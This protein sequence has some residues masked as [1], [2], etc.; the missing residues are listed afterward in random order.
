MD[1]DENR[2]L[3]RSLFRRCRAT[4]GSVQIKNPGE[5]QIRSM[6]LDLRTGREKP[7]IRHPGEYYAVNC[8]FCNDT[9]HRCYINHRYGTDDELGRAQT[10]L[11]TC[12]NAGCPLSMRKPEIYKQLE[13]MLTG[14]NLVQLRHAPI[15]EGKLVDVEK[16][17][18]TWPGIVTRVDKLPA[19]HEAVMYLAGRGFDVEVI[20]RFYNVHWCS[21]S[22]RFVCENRLIIPVYHNKQMVGWQARPAFDT[23]WKTS[24]LPKYYIS[25][26]MPRRQILYNLGNA[27]RFQTGVIVE[28]ETDVWRLG[29][30]AV[31]TFGATMT[32]PQ[33]SLFKSAF[34][35]HSGV[36]LYDP[37]VKEKT[38]DRVQQIVHELNLSLKSGFCTV[39]LP[40]GTDPG[41]LDRS[42]LRD[43]IKQKAEEKGVKVSWKKR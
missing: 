6:G 39:D 38:A 31:C 22:D 20:G 35:T 40:D 41:S 14:H 43:F 32:E 18:G 42:F 10:F 34:A 28:G 27:R 25:P 19:S 12:F 23:D 3:N 2:A 17:C 8:P 24:D 11:A 36:L 33:Q 9:R 29:P 16:I 13:E 37:D 21:K 30:Q 15:T 5:K 7:T 26:G 4:F 1:Q